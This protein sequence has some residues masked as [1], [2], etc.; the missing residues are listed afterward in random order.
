MIV[1]TID[2]GWGPDF[3]IKQFEQQLLADYLRPIAEDNRR[4]IV[5]NSVWYTT[6]L[7]NQTM[8]QLR[9]MDF[10]RIVL[11]S[12][13]DCAIPHP[14]WFTEFGREVVGVGYYPGANYL[15]FW[16]LMIGKYFDLSKYNLFDSSGIDTAYMSLNRKPHW[17]RRELYQKLC[18]LNIV[19]QG[20]VSMGGDEEFPAQR[21]LACDAGG[22]RIAPN[23]GVEQNSI[24]NDIASLGHPTNWHRHLLNVVTETVWDIHSHH[25][26]SEKI[27][28]PIVGGRPFLVYDPTGGDQ[29]LRD[30]GFE[31][32]YKDFS[33]ISNIDLTHG[34]LQPKFLHTL[35][36]Q[37]S[38][39]FQ[40]KFVALKDK[41]MYN[42]NRF[43]IYLAEQ[44]LKIKQGIQC[45]T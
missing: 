33:D 6:D 9:H 27:F 22:T 36:Q 23:A 16:A 32:Y 31:T 45:Q 11:V 28:K 18:Q 42:N 17:H 38:A 15:D 44:Q 21:I 5:I 3:P 37:N 14:D 19:D 34:D 8:E 35:C 26:V 7:H 29:W 2:E 12:M 39:Y 40:S 25:F 4:N 13:L 1:C 41:I 10:D 20:V 43:S 30:R 24:V